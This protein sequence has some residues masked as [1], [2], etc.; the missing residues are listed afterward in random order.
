[1]LY[2]PRAFIAHAAS[3]RQTCVHCGRFSTAASRR[4]LGSVSVPV[5]PDTLSG[6]LAIIAL[7]GRYP[8]NKLIARNP[9]PEQFAP[10]TVPRMPWERSIRHYPSFRMVIPVSKIGWLRVTHPFAALLA[11]RLS[12]TTCMPNP[13]RQRSF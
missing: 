2:N 1:M 13:H 11:R 5:W 9:L 6:R 4:S 3:P 10:F 12:R 7:V 8:T